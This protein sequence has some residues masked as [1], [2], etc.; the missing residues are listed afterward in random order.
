MICDEAGE[1]RNSAKP[2]MSAVLPTRPRYAH[3]WLPLKNEEINITCWLLTC[4]RVL[5]IALES[6]CSH[7]GWE[8]ATV[9]V[10]Q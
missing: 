9:H 3:E 1:H 7:F 10:N 2:A 8:E 4:K 6:E 5:S